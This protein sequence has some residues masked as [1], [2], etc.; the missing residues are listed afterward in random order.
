MVDYRTNRPQRILLIHQNQR[1]VTCLIADDL[2]MEAAFFFILDLLPV[3]YPPVK[4]DR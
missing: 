4:V 3:G 2:A 1:E